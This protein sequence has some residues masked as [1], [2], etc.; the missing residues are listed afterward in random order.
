[1]EDYTKSRPTQ[2]SEEDVYV[3]ENV[4]DESRRVIRGLPITGLKRYEYGSTQV[5]ADEVYYFKR[6]IKPQKEPA[7]ILIPQVGQI[8]MDVDNEDSMDAPSVGSQDTPLTTP[9]EKKKVKFDEMLILFIIIYLKLKN[10]KG[11]N[12]ISQITKL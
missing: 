8:P 11:K 4:Y 9:G 10:R 2:Y 1:M 5:A 7:A 6:P 12:F 3:C